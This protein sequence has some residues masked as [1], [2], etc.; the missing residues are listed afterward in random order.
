[1]KQKTITLRMVYAVLSVTIF[2]LEILIAL[3]VNDSFIRPYGGDILV[4]L[5]LCCIVRCFVP[6]G[7][8]W[9]PTAVFAFAVAVEVG[10][11]FDIVT[12]LGLGDIPFFR[13]LIGTSFSWKDIWCYA[14]GCLWFW[15]MDWP[16][17]KAC[18]RQDAHIT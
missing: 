5:L 8:H 18:I 2:I 6:K 9:M 10:Q 13:V 15:V 3:F 16:I 14:A 11:Y 4:T 1:M 17:Q 12:L 7:I